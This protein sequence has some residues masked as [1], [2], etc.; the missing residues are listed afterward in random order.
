MT[1]E[2]LLRAARCPATLADQER[3]LWRIRRVSLPPGLQAPIWADAREGWGLWS[4]G[5]HVTL[6]RWTLGTIMSTHGEV[7]MEDS[8]RELARHLQILLRAR[9]R[10]LVTGLGLGCVVRGLLAKPEVRHVDVIE[11]DAAI[12]AMVGPE[13]EGNPRITL[14]HGDAETYRGFPADAR[15]DWAW[16]DVWS[17]EENLNVVH[18]RLLK[19][20]TPV[21]T[22]QGAWQFSRWR[23]RLWPEELVA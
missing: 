13:F 22:A 5:D 23:R 12:L 14:H 6:E 9:G 8:R 19:R 3:R 20:F 7:V 16:H 15:W 21:C 17:E 18:A 2:E 1:R 11:I 10:I 4:E